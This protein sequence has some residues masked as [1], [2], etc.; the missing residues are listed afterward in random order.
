[1]TTT[2]TGVVFNLRNEIIENAAVSEAITA[3]MVPSNLCSWTLSASAPNRNCGLAMITTPVNVMAPVIICNLV[4]G[5][6]SKKYAN[7]VTNTGD[8]K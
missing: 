2:D 5:S 6:F 8:A 1:M 7:I 4:N 3:S